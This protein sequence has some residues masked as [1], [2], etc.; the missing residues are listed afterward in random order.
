M[1]AHAARP[2]IFP[3]SNPTA[4]AECTAEQ[5]YAWTDG[6]AVFGGGSPFDAV[7]HAGARIEPAQLRHFTATFAPL[8]A[9]AEQCDCRLALENIYEDTPVT[10]TAVVEAR[11]RG[12]G[13]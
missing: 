6:R 13:R 4:N 11:A 5:A 9:L 7:E 2:I 12:H 3:L 1:A 10:L 8:L